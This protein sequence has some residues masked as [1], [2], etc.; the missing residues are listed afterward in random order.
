MAHYFI[1]LLHTVH[2]EK[3][4]NV[5]LVAFVYKSSW[6]SSPG[7]NKEVKGFGDYQRDFAGKKDQKY[8]KVLS[9]K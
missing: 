2:P 8:L 3:M 7:R 1:F 6:S 5:N 4:W 9:E